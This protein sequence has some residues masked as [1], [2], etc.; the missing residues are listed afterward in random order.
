MTKNKVCIFLDVFL[1]KNEIQEEILTKLGYESYWFQTN[2]AGN[3]SQTKGRLVMSRNPVKRIVYYLK[4]LL[5]HR[6]TL[7]HAEVYTGGRMVFVTILLL[8]LFGIHVICVE[9]GDIFIHLQNKMDRFTAFSMRWSFNLCH[10]IWYKEVYMLAAL[11]NLNPNKRKEF[12]HNAV[13]LPETTISKENKDIDFLWVNRVL[14]ERN[15]DWFTKALSEEELR[16]SKACLLGVPT[17]ADGSLQLHEHLSGLPENLIPYPYQNPFPYYK[18]ARFFILPARIVFGNHALM[19]AMS[20]G[21]VPIVLQSPGVELM[22]NHM[23]NGFVCE[24]YNSFLDC[25]KEAYFLQ[26]DIYKRMS[27]RN[28]EIIRKEFSPDYLYSKL[29][30][31]YEMV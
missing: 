2:A 22:V 8:R 13:Y 18:R 29:K 24:D 5:K 23:D 4:F 15:P 12:I 19:E 16:S 11:N 21:L 28:K 17:N 25:M 1:H 3:S 14:S 6:G 10:V 27:E 9:R 30:L 26:P 20:Y 7:H 31:L